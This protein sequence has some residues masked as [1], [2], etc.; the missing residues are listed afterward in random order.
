MTT[1]RQLLAAEFTIRRLDPAAV[2]RISNAPALTIPEALAV[3][4]PSSNR[5]RLATLVGAGSDGELEEMLAAAEAL[6][7]IVVTSTTEV[8]VIGGW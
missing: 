1:P 3:D 8:L 5:V 6:K 4:Y 7:Q 2:V